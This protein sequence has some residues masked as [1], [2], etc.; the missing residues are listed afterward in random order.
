MPIFGY[1]VP[2]PYVIIFAIVIIIL[3]ALVILSF[4]KKDK[5]D[6]IN[7]D[8]DVTGGDF[9][10]LLSKEDFDIKCDNPMLEAYRVQW[11]KADPGKQKD[12]N[13]ILYLA[14]KQLTKEQLESETE[15]S[16]AECEER[17]DQLI[18]ELSKKTG[19]KVISNTDE[20]EFEDYFNSEIEEDEV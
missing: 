19:I 2:I 16:Q 9:G 15:W 12:V 17:M 8:D 1:E 18:D 14:M 13:L 20:S 11:I 5:T 7:E 6:I 3:L 10:G 4:T